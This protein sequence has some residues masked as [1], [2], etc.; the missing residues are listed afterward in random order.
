MDVRKATL[1][2]EAART[3]LSASSSFCLVASAVYCEY[4]SIRPPEV[5]LLC[6]FEPRAVLE[7][8]QVPTTNH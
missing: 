1:S 8:P 6:G 4:Y 5:L 7:V 3:A 2:L